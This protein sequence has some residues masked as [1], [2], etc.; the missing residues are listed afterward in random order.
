MFRE[1]VNSNRY[2]AQIQIKDEHSMNFSAMVASKSAELFKI[3][4]RKSCFGLLPLSDRNV[5]QFG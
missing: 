5:I 1:S 4:A 3:P 2:I